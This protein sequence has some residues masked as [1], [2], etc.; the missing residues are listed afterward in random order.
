MIAILM[1]ATTKWRILAIMRK[2]PCLIVNK[3]NTP[4]MPYQC[5][6]LV[7]VFLL[8]ACKGKPTPCCFPQCMTYETM[9]DTV[10]E[11]F[12]IFLGFRI[13][14]QTNTTMLAECKSIANALCTS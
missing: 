2:L 1:K 5:R 10:Y 11:H 13:A 9:A 14:A 7:G 6:L 3:L 8:P 12:W 4:D